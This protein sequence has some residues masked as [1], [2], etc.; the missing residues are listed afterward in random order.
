MAQTAFNM[1]SSVAKAHLHAYLLQHITLITCNML[2][3]IWYNYLVIT[4]STDTGQPDFQQLLGIL[5]F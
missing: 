3:A 1:L 4:L 2:R 5:S